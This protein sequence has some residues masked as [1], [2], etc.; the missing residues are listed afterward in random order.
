M[1]KPLLSSMKFESYFLP[2]ERRMEHTKEN[3]VRWFCGF[4]EGEGCICNDMSNNN[5]L[6]LS[7]AQN[8]SKPLEI[9][10][11]IWGGIIHKRIRKSPASDK[12][13]EGHEWRLSHNDSLQF[14]DDIKPFMLIPYKINQ[15][16]LAIE[17]AKKGL[18]RRFPC[19]KCDDDFA[20]PAGRRRHFKNFHENTD[21]SVM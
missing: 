15:V 16:E 3:V 6:R 8:D 2:I 11:K 7:I 13:C 21:A 5:K 10:Q 12:M 17:K 20:S 4:Y 9:G 18:D 1:G 19:S 14:I